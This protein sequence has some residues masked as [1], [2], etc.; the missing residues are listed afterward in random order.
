MRLIWV[1]RGRTWGFR[2]LHQEGSEDPLPVYEDVFSGLEDEPEVWRRLAD[3]GALRIRDPFGRQ[4]A[5]GRVIPHDF[6]VF[7]PEVDEIHSVEDGRGVVWPLV[8]DKFAELWD[9][10]RPPSVDG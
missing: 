9:Q 1:T 3:K 6:V 10:P 2:F 8:A 4:D 5:A 7:G